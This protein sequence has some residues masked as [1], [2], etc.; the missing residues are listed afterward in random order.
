MTGADAAGR[1]PEETGQGSASSG[2][3]T[4]EPPVEPIAAPDPLLPNR[5]ARQSSWVRTVGWLACFGVVVSLPLW[6]GGAVAELLVDI[7]VLVALASAW[8][9]LAGFAGRPLLATA[10][11]AGTGTVA[12]AALVD[13]LAVNPVVALAGA[14]AAAA[15]VG[16]VVGAVAAR[17]DAAWGA[18]ATLALAVAT[19]DLARLLGDGVEP[20]DGAVA[21]NATLRRGL[22]TWLA[23][24]VGA[25]TVAAVVAVRRSRVGLGLVAARDDAD[26]AASLGVRPLLP[27]TVF[28][29]AAAAAAGLAGAVSHLQRG[30]V[31]P[32]QAFDTL[33]WTWPAVV[34]ALV[35]GLRT[36]AGPVVGA[37]VVVLAERLLDGRPAL[38]L[39]LSGLA[40]LVVLVA[41]PL[42]IAGT[43]DAR[44]GDARRER[45]TRR[46]SPR[47]RSEMRRE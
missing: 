14:A 9:W 26:A 13:G 1:D 31:E 11:F 45:L 33:T 28:V 12:W 34:A 7:G 2:P 21:L 40:V 27:T 43:L 22:A 37:V 35:G 10:T 32:T 3:V 39:L 25:G 44:L 4:S 29:A 23:V 36:T 38:F 30:A 17:L 46:W 5:V 6:V 8:G 42:G 41:A 47:R 18:A 24:V 20:V 19:S 15:L 16:L